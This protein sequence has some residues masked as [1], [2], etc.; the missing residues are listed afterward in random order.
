MFNRRPRTQ[1]HSAASNAVYQNIARGGVW[2]PAMSGIL[3][4]LGGFK[5]GEM[6]KARFQ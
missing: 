5:A 3:P 4:E 2:P 6:K 1:D